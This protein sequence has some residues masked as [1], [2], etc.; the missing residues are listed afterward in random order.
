MKSAPDFKRILASVESDMLAIQQNL[1][2][3]E[4]APNFKGS[5]LRAVTQQLDRFMG[6]MQ[7][8]NGQTARLP[9]L[10]RKS[11]TRQPTTTE[12]RRPVRATLME[13]RTSKALSNPQRAFETFS[14]KF[15]VQRVSRPKSRPIGKTT[16]SKPKFKRLSE[17]SILPRKYRDDPSLEPLPITT[18]DLAKGMLELL[19]Q[20]RIPKEVDL[21]P[22]FERGKPVF[23]HQPAKLNEW[24]E[25]LALPYEAKM[26][27]L[28]PP[29]EATLLPTYQSISSDSE[30]EPGLQ[31]A[32]FA[33]EVKNYDSVMDT[34]SVHNII[35]RRG[36]VLTT[37]PE[38][39]SFKRTQ[40]DNW[41]SISN[42]LAKA[43]ALF[44]QHGIGIVVL[45]GR[46]LAEVVCD[47]LRPLRDADILDCVINQSQVLPFMQSSSYKFKLAD[48]PQ[49][50]AVLIQSAWRRFHA[51]SAYLQLLTLINK[52]RLI[53]VHF[54]LY[55]KHKALKARISKYREERYKRLADLQIQLTQ[56]W[57]SI[58]HQQ[59]LEIHLGHYSPNGPVPRHN[60]NIGGVFSMKDGNVDVVFLTSEP[61]DADIKTYYYNILELRDVTEPQARLTF[62]N[63]QEVPGTAPHSP[64]FLAR[65]CPKT[66]EK[67]RKMTQQKPAYIVA[68]RLTADEIA[69]AGE[70]GLPL[71]GGELENTAY[72]STKSGAKLIF[73]LSD[74]PVPP[75]LTDCS[76][77]DSVIAS[78]AKLIM[79]NPTIDQ[80]LIKLNKESYSRGIAIVTVGQSR[81][82]N[83]LRRNPTEV[84]YQKLKETLQAFLPEL[85]RFVMPSR[86]ENWQHFASFLKD[87]AVVEATPPTPVN[88]M[89]V[90]FFLS[91]SGDVT[92]VWPYDRLQMTD[93]AATGIMFPQV[94][95]PALDVMTL[96]RSIG[97]TLLRK[98][99]W[100]YVKADIAVFM[101]PSQPQSHPLF[102]AVDLSIGMCLAASVFECFDFLSDGHFDIKVN[103]YYI[104]SVS[105]VIDST[106]HEI[107]SNMVGSR[108]TRRIRSPSQIDLSDYT[109]YSSRS[110]FFLEH[111]MHTML[112]SLSF[113]AFFELCKKEAMHFDL[114]FIK[115]T[116]FLFYNRLSCKSI[117]CL[118]VGQ[119]RMEAIANISEVCRFLL[120]NL[121]PLPK[122]N[123][124][125]RGVPRDD[126]FVAETVAK[127]KFSQRF[128]ERT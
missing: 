101:D 79:S 99:I 7:K 120:R 117:G 119:D 2:T 12:I 105:G 36:K 104:E 127:I 22:A 124:L 98:G 78:L 13:S 107:T 17:P 48:G 65:L 18:D 59:R 94:S 1:A 24:R 122:A 60:E 88:S 68:T 75:S 121:G 54:R 41:T 63:P 61:L 21:T 47:E 76:S 25:Q 26:L 80:W 27:A 37:T 90:V 106:K 112:P 64:A 89:S 71:L 102:W 23:S 3:L 35:L 4:D 103:R 81:T 92:K 5:T 87:G 113:R 83:E 30:D 11:M 58:Q 82:I 77:Q 45:D 126:I 69:F 118:A 53:Q 49:F 73:E 72:T 39:A 123:K 44:S 93:F 96:C 115:G 28:L 34:Y 70:L 85:T 97:N 43:E 100:G 67:L 66:L 57:G 95:L 108:E 10:P 16:Y 15:N 29:S 91:P 116:S 6:E 40:H 109:K 19:N 51:R 62:L 55:L 52:A 114:E 86:Y 46:K 31:L 32:V 14:A 50:A 8:S 110:F 9:K 74:I 84:S 125:Y 33:P 42:A 56:N 128:I 38:Y 20:G 111:F